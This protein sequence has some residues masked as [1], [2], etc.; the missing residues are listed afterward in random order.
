MHFTKY[1]KT[2]VN[3]VHSEWVR[4]VRTSAAVAI[5]IYAYVYIYT[6]L[7]S[8][9]QYYIKCTSLFLIPFVCNYILCTVG[10]ESR[11]EI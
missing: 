10:T 8:T 9:V 1:I 4:H 6:V 11:K 7:Q 5:Y 2:H 3:V